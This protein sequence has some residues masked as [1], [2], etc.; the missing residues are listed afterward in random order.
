[1]RSNNIINKNIKLKF[2]FFKSIS[3]YVES[4]FKKSLLDLKNLIL[5]L[6]QKV[7]YEKFEK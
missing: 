7:K 3:I 4:N 1:M 5:F 6:K 2:V